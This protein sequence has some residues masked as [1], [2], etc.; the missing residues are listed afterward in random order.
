MLILKDRIVIWKLIICI[1]SFGGL[2]GIQYF[3]YPFMLLD[4][5]PRLRTLN[6]IVMAIQGNARTF[7]YTLLL[8]LIIIY[9][10]SILGFTFF[11]SDFTGVS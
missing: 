7:I 4:L 8:L 1:L 11:R 2:F 10:Y 3:F 5:I 6:N 9:I